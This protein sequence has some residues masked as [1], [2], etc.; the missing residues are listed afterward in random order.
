MHTEMSSVEC[1]PAFLPSYFAGEC[2]DRFDATHVL[3]RLHRHLPFHE[4]RGRFSV[5]CSIWCPGFQHQV[6]EERVVQWSTRECFYPQKRLTVG[7]ASTLLLF[8]VR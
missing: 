7:P 6:K 2:I 8:H 3:P 4:S 5:F 1:L